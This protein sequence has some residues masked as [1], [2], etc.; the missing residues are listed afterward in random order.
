MNRFFDTSAL[1]PVFNENHV[2]HGP[3]FQAFLSANKKTCCCAAHSLAEIYAVLTRLPG[4]NRLSG[5]Q[6]LLLLEE[7]SF[8]LTLIALTGEEYLLS[9]K[10]AASRGITGGGVYDYLLFCCAQKA[11][12]E[13]IYTWN[14]K[15]FQ[16]FDPDNNHRVST[17]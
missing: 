6:A 5:D 15:H 8:R 11:K 16:Q 12:A 14:L 4:K 9:V 13:T 2:H 3:S 1:I 7:V 10:Q 17:P